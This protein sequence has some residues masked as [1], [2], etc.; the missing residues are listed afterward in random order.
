MPNQATI[1]IVP[2][3]RDHVPAH[4]QTL[5]AAKLPKVRSVAPLEHDKLSCAARVDAIERTLADIEGPVIIV[6]HSAGTMM[7][8]HWAQRATRPIQGALLATPSDMETPMPAGY[9]TVDQL[10]SN[11]WLPIPRNR[12][13]FPTIL[14]ASS[15]DP[16]SRLERARALAETWGSRFVELGA[17]GHLNPA[18]GFGEWPRAEEL[19]RELSLHAV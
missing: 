3:L 9:P 12:L 17:V 1:L 16:L 6:A 7:V 5:L 18:S 2:G 19:I 8:A 13:P 15:N 10:D 14:A 11:G 4:W